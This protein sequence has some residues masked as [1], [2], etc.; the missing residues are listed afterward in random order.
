VTAA[1]SPS[2]AMST[3]AKTTR[4]SATA[5][6]PT[7]E[8]IGRC[9]DGIADLAELARGPIGGEGNLLGVLEA[10]QGRFGY[11]PAA[12]LEEI[13]RRARVPLSRIYA[14]VSFYSQLYTEPRGRHTVRCCRGTACHVKGA[15][16]VLDTVRRVLGIDDG[17]TTPDRQF[18][19]ETIACL[20]ACFLSPAMMVDDKCYGQLT[21]QRV[22]GIL[23]SYR[24][25]KA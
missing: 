16:R 7:A 4:S 13:S 25:E 12:A 19:L 3:E 18:T 1:E 21:P 10:V 11:L 23:K 22:Q 24:S 14:V 8:D 5:W 6:Q 9:L 20:G 2:L 15:E 17:Q